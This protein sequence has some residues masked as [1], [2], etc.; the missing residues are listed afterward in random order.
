MKYCPICATTYEDK[1]E[2]CELDGVTLQ[3]R[4][5][6]DPYF[7]KLIKGRY[8]ILSKLGQGGMGTVY[9][10]EQVSVGRKVALKVLQGSYAEDANSSADSAARR[11]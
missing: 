5:K 3:V 9:L 11:G 1:I 2:F 4:G 10:A 7:G 8:R 6:Q